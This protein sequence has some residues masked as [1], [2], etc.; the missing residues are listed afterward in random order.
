[1][2]PEV[3]STIQIW[4]WISV[5]FWIWIAVG[6]DAS[7]HQHRHK[8]KDVS[9][10]AMSSLH[11]LGFAPL[12]PRGDVI[13]GDH[14]P[15]DERGVLRAV[16]LARRHANRFLRKRWGRKLQVDMLDSQVRLQ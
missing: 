13:A 10:R 15:G 14:H 7:K 16:R 8:G 12:S 9:D 4:S 5:I 1:M 3:R 6:T 2:S 11:V